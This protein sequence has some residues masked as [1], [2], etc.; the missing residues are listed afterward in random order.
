MAIDL[1]KALDE[2]RTKPRVGMTVVCFLDGTTDGRTCSGKVVKVHDRDR[3]EL[4]L[5][6]GERVSAR[7]A[8][9]ASAPRPP[10]SW[11]FIV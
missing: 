4:L 3:V 1:G 5:R 11:D 7:Y 2:K 8:S 6:T 10:M 9:A